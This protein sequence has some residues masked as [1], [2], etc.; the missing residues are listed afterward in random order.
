MK[1][2]VISSSLGLQPK[3]D[4]QED[5]EDESL[6]NFNTVT[7]RKQEKGTE[8]ESQYMDLKE[9]ERTVLLSVMEDSYANV[10]KKAAKYKSE[11]NSLNSENEQRR[12][13]LN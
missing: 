9:S 3:P 10:L 8:T 5:E 1:R 7:V 4:Y 13:H 11:R 12:K 2:R 6:A